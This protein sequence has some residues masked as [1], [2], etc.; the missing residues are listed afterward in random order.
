VLRCAWLDGL[1][2]RHFRIYIFV[3]EPGAGKTTAA[4]HLVAYDLWRRG[5]VDSY[6]EG[7]SEAAA[8]LQLSSGLE[9]LL[10]YIRD[11][12]LSKGRDWLIIDDAAVDYHYVADPAVWSRVMDVFKIAR[13]AVA[14]R[15]IIFTTAAPEFLSLRL[16]HTAS[17]YYVKRGDMYYTTRLLDGRCNIFETEEKERYVAV[18]RLAANLVGTI[19]Y[20]RWHR[21][22]KATRWRL[23]GLIPVAPEFAMPAEIE[24]VHI[25]RRT[26]RAINAIDEA[27]E[28]LR[29]RQREE[30]GKQLNNKRK[31]L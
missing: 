9:E 31:N 25:E 22:R 28:R 5:V 6:Q 24:E 19:D 2:S 23:A 20:K 18:V 1:W 17:V 15:G 7:L 14:Q 21:V 10:E 26:A 27:L 12:M 16:R 8:R 30:G 4:L 3:G 11:F 13:A 29:K